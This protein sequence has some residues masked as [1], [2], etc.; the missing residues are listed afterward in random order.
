MWVSA[1]FHSHCK[2][3]SPPRGE[4]LLSTSNA[5]CGMVHHPPL[6]LAYGLASTTG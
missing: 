6:T 5:H 2:E 3:S 4:F 1:T